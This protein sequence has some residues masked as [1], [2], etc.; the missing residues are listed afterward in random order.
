NSMLKIVEDVFGVTGIDP[1]CVEL[2]F[3]ESV[4]MRNWDSSIGMLQRLKAMGVQLSLDDFGAG[5]SSLTYLQR[6]P[7]NLVKIDRT[8]L[9]GGGAVSE[10]PTMVKAIIAM[11]HGL[12][13]QVMAKGVEHTEQK[14][15]LIAEACDQA[16]GYLFGRPMPAAEFAALVALSTLPKAS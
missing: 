10:L 11:A 2:E 3:T 8:L 6:M 5:L 9:I 7:V 1:G 12:E 14:A 16:Q 13:L 4:V 15:C